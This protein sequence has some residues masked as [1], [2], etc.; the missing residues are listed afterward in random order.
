MAYYKSFRCSTCSTH[1]PADDEFKLCLTC[2]GQCWRNQEEPDVT[3]EEATSIRRLKEFEG[4]CERRDRA[5]AEALRAR[6]VSEAP[7]YV[8]DVLTS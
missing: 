1:W 4:F 3:K 7:L 8:E 2:G 6:L 5:T